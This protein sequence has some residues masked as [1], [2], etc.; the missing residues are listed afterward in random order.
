MRWWGERAEPVAAAAATHG[1]CCSAPLGVG[2]TT[3]GITGGGGTST[4]CSTGG[5]GV[6]IEDEASVRWTYCHGDSVHV[7]VGAEVVDA[8]VQILTSDNTVRS[9]GPHSTSRSTPLTAPCSAPKAL[10]RSVRG[11]GV[12]GQASTQSSTLPASGCA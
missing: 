1:L 4:G 5:I 7:Q 12:L 10:L 11:V 2:H 9:S 3:G 8:G 6:T